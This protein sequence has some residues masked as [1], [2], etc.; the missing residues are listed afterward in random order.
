VDAT[1]RAIDSL[2]QVEGTLEEF[3][4]QAIS[5]GMDAVGEVSV[6]LRR[7][8]TL[9]SGH[10]ADTDIVVAAA[11]AYVQA[12]NRMAARW[13]APERIVPADAGVPA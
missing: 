12:L 2:V 13:N 3:A 11:R 1:Y 8:G 5:G 4:I 9:V 7:D 6:R 10:G